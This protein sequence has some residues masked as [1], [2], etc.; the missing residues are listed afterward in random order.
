MKPETILKALA[1]TRPALL[2]EARQTRKKRSVASYCLKPLAG[3]AAA[4]ALFVLLI[5]VSPTV[6]KACEDI[7]ILSKLTEML[8]FHSS[9]GSL[10]AAVNHDY[11]QRVDQHQ[12]IDGVTVNVDYMIMDQK[13]LT[14]FYRVDV[15]EDSKLS[16]SEWGFVEGMNASGGYGSIVDP[17]YEGYISTFVF[18][19]NAPETLK[20]QFGLLDDGEVTGK[21]FEFL[22][23]PTLLPIKHIDADQTLELD[24][25]RIRITGI[26]IYPSMMSFSLETDPDNTAT[27]DGIDFYAMTDDGTRYQ[28]SSLGSCIESPIDDNQDRYEIHTDS[29]YFENP[30]SV[31]LC[32][33]RT[34][35]GYKEHEKGATSIRFNPSTGTATGL[36][37]D[38][39]IV[40]YSKQDN[41]DWHLTLRTRNTAR[42]LCCIGFCLD[43]EECWRDVRDENPDPNVVEFTTH[44]VNTD[45]VMLWLDYNLP[46]DEPFTA[47]FALNP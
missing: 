30:S 2:D 44:S 15:P 10:S 27:L 33:E 17:D 14:V 39:E 41:G 40:D 12:T 4:F 29:P 22:L 24:G 34:Y 32:V 25:Q 28:R 1:E 46:C 36:P 9:S 7:P 18:S 21:Y 13:S 6:A 31:T 38:I 11:Y 19:G 43:T 45:E 5:N 47:T 8:G 3:L 20:L 26:D 37:A 16:I 23:E 35:W 42:E